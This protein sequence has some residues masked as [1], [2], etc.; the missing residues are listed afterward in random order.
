MCHARLEYSWG[1]PSKIDELGLH[2]MTEQLSCAWCMPVRQTHLTSCIRDRHTS[3]HVSQS[4]HMRSTCGQYTP[5]TPFWFLPSQA[6]LDLHSTK[7]V[8]V[9]ILAQGTNWA[10]AVTQAYTIYCSSSTPPAV[11]VKDVWFLHLASNTQFTAM[12]TILHSALTEHCLWIT[13]DCNTFNL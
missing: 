10:D 12:K 3:L 5:L 1:S 6:W 7:S 9:A 13:L 8:T 2:G 11:G 4:S